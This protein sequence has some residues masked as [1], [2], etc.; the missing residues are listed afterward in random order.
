MCVRACGVFL[1]YSYSGCSTLTHRHELAATLFDAL[2]GAAQEDARG[3]A[4]EEPAD[5]ADDAGGA[6]GEADHRE[7]GAA[8]RTRA[9][10]SEEVG[11]EFI[12]GRRTR[13]SRR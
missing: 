8:A 13:Q 12:R 9:V 7:D 6:S 4:G 3:D 5:R 1:L 2:R 11:S 10:Q